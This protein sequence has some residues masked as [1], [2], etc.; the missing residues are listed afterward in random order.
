MRLE[1]GGLGIRLE[2]EDLAITNKVIPET[3]HNY[4]T[5]D[6]GSV[7]VPGKIYGA[8]SFTQISSMPAVWQ[9]MLLAPFQEGW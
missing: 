4:F 6:I 3:K 9:K 5:C 2:Q 7:W 1:Q 8:S